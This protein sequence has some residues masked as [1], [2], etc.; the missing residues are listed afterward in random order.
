MYMAGLAA[1]MSGNVSHTYDQYVGL[2]CTYSPLPHPSAQ[3]ECRSLEWLLMSCT[4]RGE[5]LVL[6][7]PVSATYNSR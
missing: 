7:A 3:R 2:V 4:P 1:R 6:P 5:G